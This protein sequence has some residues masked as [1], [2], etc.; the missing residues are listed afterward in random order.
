MS[1]PEKSWSK[2]VNRESASRCSKMNLKKSHFE[3]SIVYSTYLLHSMMRI[4]FCLLHLIHRNTMHD[5]TKMLS[6][7]L[8]LGTIEK[9]S[10]NSLSLLS[11]NSNLKH[12][13]FIKQNRRTTR[14]R[15]THRYILR[16]MSFVWCNEDIDKTPVTKTRKDSRHYLHVMN[17]VRKKNTE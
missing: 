15:I 7:M 5:Q 10:E 14:Q 4:S 9:D 6:A 17:G 8:I 16:D 3:C 2:F 12:S 11:A 1:I 13:T